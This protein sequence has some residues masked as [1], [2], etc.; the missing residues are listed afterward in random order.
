[1]ILNNSKPS[2]LE[3]I[4]CQSAKSVISEHSQKMH[5]SLKIIS[6]ICPLTVVAHKILGL[7]SLT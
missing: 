6:R 4:T 5:G 3:A 1:M 2:L 7:S